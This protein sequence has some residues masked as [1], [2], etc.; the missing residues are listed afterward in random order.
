MHNPK[1]FSTDNCFNPLK[2]PYGDVSDLHWGSTD[3]EK[4]YYHNLKKYHGRMHYSATDITYNFNSFGYRSPEPQ[5]NDMTPCVVYLGCSYTSGVG[6]PEHECWTTLVH[7]GIEA[8]LGTSLG[9]HNLGASGASND[10]IAR[11]SLFLKAINP[12][13]VFVFYTSILRREYIGRN[14]CHYEDAYG[15]H[16]GAQAK[17][18]LDINDYNNDMYNFI[19]NKAFIESVCSQ[20]APLISTSFEPLP[21][22]SDAYFFKRPDYNAGLGD[23]LARD[24]LHPGRIY[25][26]KLANEF[27][28]AFHSGDAKERV[29]KVLAI[30]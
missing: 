14:N 24:M 22:P 20:K 15:P 18:I 2:L 13:L 17:Q 10:S 30:P 3:S 8:S 21:I 12:V 16:R 4:N 6:L 29:K 28:Q 25:H 11:R 7:K 27:L 9:Y 23:P 19:K 1:I 5:V 26:E